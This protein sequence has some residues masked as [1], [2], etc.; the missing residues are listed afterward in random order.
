LLRTEANL[1]HHLQVNTIRDDLTSIL[2]SI[3]VTK[4]SLGDD[5][6][7]GS[8]GAGSTAAAQSLS[9]A[10]LPKL[11]ADLNKVK[12]DLRGVA[13]GAERLRKKARLMANSLAVLE[14]SGVVGECEDGERGFWR[15]WRGLR[16]CCRRW[17]GCGRRRGR[18]EGCRGGWEMGS[19]G[20]LVS[21]CSFGNLE[22]QME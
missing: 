12:A 18:R 14:G 11:D 2:H 10:F 13:A 1:H 16:W 7:T 9:S 5:D 22:V 17:G 4:R 8:M 20:G 19:H 3:D 21:V 15:R 6:D